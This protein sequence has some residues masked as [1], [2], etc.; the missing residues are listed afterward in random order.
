M[1]RT[2][3]RFNR[4]HLIKTSGAAGM[5][6]A[7]SLATLPSALAAT[8]VASPVATD[9][10]HAITT[11]MASLEIPG[12]IAL[13][14][15]DGSAPWTRGFG[16]A[17]LASGTPMDP[18]MHLRVGSITKT[19]TATAVLQLVDDGALALD[20][21]LA[22]TLPDISAF[23]HAA[24]MTIR[25]MLGMRSGAFDYLSDTSVFLR[26]ATNPT[27]AWTPDELI[28]TSLAN[29]PAFAPGERFAY[30]NTNSILLGMIVEHLT[31][32][33]LATTFSDRLFAPL[34]M[35]HT[36]LPSDTGLPSP[37]ARG[38]GAEIVARGA[39]PAVAMTGQL[40]DWTELNP[41]MAG[42]AGGVVST[43]GDLHIWLQALTRG[44]LLSDALQR[45]RMTFPEHE[46]G[47][48]APA[49]EYGLG[50]GRYDGMVGHDGSIFGFD[51][52]IGHDPASGTSIVTLIN[53][54]PSP[55]DA[56][57]AA[58]AMAIREA[59]ARAP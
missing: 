34:G 20:D 2:R 23:P 52:F 27:R 21:T 38:Y 30:S 40:K 19:M 14:A 1:T 33:P 28:D 39:T 7:T 13:V 10:E 46:P 3:D 5:L 4:R 44:S 41:S 50:I 6:A 18:A 47:P 37:H 26:M 58:V 25:Q 59:L 36:S 48:D 45:E 43:V 42:A 12:A 55:N 24:E 57:A 15:R 31:G 29:D 8:P 22:G 53:V 54:F 9:L 11:T 35:H 32:Q 16:T 17:D 49:F 51:G 56:S